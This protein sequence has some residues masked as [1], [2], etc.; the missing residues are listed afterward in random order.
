[1]IFDY[2]HFGDVVT[3]DTTFR[4]NKECRPFGIFVGFNHYRETVIF[5]AALLYDETASSFQWLFETFL[6]TMCGKKPKTIFTDQDAAMAKAISLVMPDTYHCLCVWHIM[7]NAMKHL[8]HLFKE[9][10]EFSKRFNAC[11]FDYKT[12][13][14]LF[15][16]WEAL[17]NDYDPLREGWLPSIFTL[18]E[19]WAKAY[20]KKVF[21]AGMR[22]TQLSESL[23]ADLKNYLKVDLDIIQLFTHFERV[24]DDKRYKE[25][26]AEYNCQ[27]KLPRLKMKKA[28]MLVQASK[29]YTLKF[30][31]NSRR[32]TKNIKGP[33][34]KIIVLV[35]L[36]TSI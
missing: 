11:I 25:W 30:L 17:L 23:N 20:I 14:E 5:G 27:H 6:K 2:G 31:K 28:G 18:K 12:E 24:L 29:L 8:G 7:Q 4:T 32:S 3:F 21:S 26:E 35:L 1:M 33:L 36:H 9:G 15:T 34:S 13:E 19:K 16:H 10:S 22:S